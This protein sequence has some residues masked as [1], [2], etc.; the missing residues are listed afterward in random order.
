VFAK[1]TYTKY[2][3]QLPTLLWDGN[4]DFCAYWT[5]NWNKVLGSK[6]IFEAYQ[7]GGKKFPDLNPDELKQASRLIEADGQIFIGPDSAYRSLYLAGKYKFLHRAYRRM[8]PFAYLSD[9]LYQWVANHR[10]VS[11]VLTKY[12]F[13]SNPENLR[14]FWAIYLFVLLFLL[15]F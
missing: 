9:S 1:T 6:V 7:N 15:V 8:K 12:L 13:G 10:K 5:T 3:P 2:P 14:P 11:F 4:C